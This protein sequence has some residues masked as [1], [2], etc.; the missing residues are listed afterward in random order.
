MRNIKTGTC[1]HAGCLYP[2]EKRQM[3]EINVHGR[4]KRALH[5]AAKGIIVERDCSMKVVKFNAAS[6]RLL[7]RAL[8]NITIG[9]TRYI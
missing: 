2:A 1:A 5:D 8:C 6:Y 4:L 9:N 7:I 3:I